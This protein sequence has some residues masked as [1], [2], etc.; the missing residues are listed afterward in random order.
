MQSL[1]THAEEKPYGCEACGKSFIES[2]IRRKIIALEFIQKRNLMIMKL[3][4]KP[5]KTITQEC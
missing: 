4:A 5:H 2:S 1:Q 3:V